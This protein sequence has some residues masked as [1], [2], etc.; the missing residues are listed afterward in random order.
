M[1]RAA[2]PDRHSVRTS[3]F[4]P[5]QAAISAGSVFKRGERGV[6]PATTASTLGSS[7]RASRTASN[8]SSF[9]MGVRSRGFL[10]SARASS[11]ASRRIR[12]S[13]SLVSSE[14]GAITSAPSWP[15]ILSAAP[16]DSKPALDTAARRLPATV[17]WCK[18]WDR[19]KSPSNSEK[20]SATITPACR[21]Q[22]SQTI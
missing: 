20:V 9:I 17:L 22:D 10:T 3:L 19:Q 18:A 7:Q 1:E 21:M 12:E 11:L 14:K 5:I 13:F 15:S 8:T 16:T 6:T 4:F 2:W